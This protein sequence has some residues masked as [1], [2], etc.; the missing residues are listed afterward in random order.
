MGIILNWHHRQGNLWEIKL[1]QPINQPPAQSTGYEL[2]FQW[3]TNYPFRTLHCIVVTVIVKVVEEEEVEY[4][5]QSIR[6]NIPIVCPLGVDFM[7]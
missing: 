2:H 6:V 5:N 3:V 4:P 1:F 7:V